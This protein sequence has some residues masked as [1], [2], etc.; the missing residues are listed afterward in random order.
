[1]LS[2]PSFDFHFSED[3]LFLN[4]FHMPVGAFFFCYSVL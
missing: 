2:H 1:M 3:K 4:I